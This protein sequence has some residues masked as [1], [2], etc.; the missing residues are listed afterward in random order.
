MTLW[1]CRLTL[2]DSKRTVALFAGSSGW[3]KTLGACH[4]EWLE[5]SPGRHVCQFETELQPVGQLRK[6]SRRWA[7][8]TLLL[9]Y[10]DEGNRIKD[11][12]KAKAGQIEHCEISY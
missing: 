4:I 2:V 7:H 3:K 5:L 11:L 12:A 1:K 6:V 10:E 8:L 9:D